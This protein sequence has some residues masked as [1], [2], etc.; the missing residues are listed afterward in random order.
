MNQESAQEN[1]AASRSTGEGRRPPLRLTVLLNGRG[2]Q[3][4]YRI[5]A[6]ADWIWC[7]GVID[8]ALPVGTVIEV[9]VRERRKTFTVEAGVA[10]AVLDFGT[11]AAQGGDPGAHFKTYTLSPL[12]AQNTFREQTWNQASPPSLEAL[13]A[14]A[15]RPF[16][17]GNDDAVACYEAAWRMLSRKFHE[18]LPGSGFSRDFVYT[19]FAN[20]IFIWGCCFITMFGR[21][22]ARAFP[23]IETLDNFYGKQ[24]DDG[25][26][27][28]QMGIYDGRSAFERHDLSSVGGNIFAWAECLAYEQ[29]RD[30]DR[31]RRVYPVLLAYHR[32]LRAHRTWKDGT[33]FGSGW[34]C[35]MDNIPRIDPERYNIHFEHG[36][37]SFVDIT[38]QQIFNARNLL[39]IAREIGVD[40]GVAELEDE[41]AAL[42]ALANAQ[43]WDEALGVYCDLDRAGRRVPVPHVG[44][45][46]ALLAGVA[47]PERQR[48]LVEA[49]DDPARFAVAC[50][51]AS[52]ARCV[53]GFEPDG[54]NYWRGGVWC[55]T[56]FMIAQGLHA[57]GLHADAAR[58]A[59]R[60][61]NAIVQVFRDT[62]SIW[63]SYD[64]S[65]VAPGKNIG[66][67]VRNEFVGFSGVTPIALFLEDVIGV[68]VEDGEIVWRIR[69][70]ERHGVRNLHLLGSTLDL[71]CEARSNPQETPRTT[72]HA[73]PPI[74]VRVV[75]EHGLHDPL[76]LS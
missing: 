58:I 35:G 19:E 68:R 37:I 54:G 65:R 46:W 38:L 52:T 61:V 55:I 7:E 32:W 39:R 17:A 44:T 42:T 71:V 30:R 2:A 11:A 70:L 45:F 57:C 50:G 29:T 64:P 40:A 67:L 15:P 14:A 12:V 66:S 18:P 6:A 22:A 75:L 34:G 31:L 21:Y 1:P 9:E 41:S 27:P 36:H 47:T 33:Y 43:M 59:E 53:P 74:P 26:I 13:L 62:G 24:E 5:G 4:R 10:E 63:E 69:Q 76:P 72:I 48:K 20:A 3:G 49:L 16:L 25:F 8:A 23:F 28:R 51:T 73:D 56:D 60:H